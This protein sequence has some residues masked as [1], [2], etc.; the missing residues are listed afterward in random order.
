LA[1]VAG[2]MTVDQDHPQ[3]LVDASGNE[4]YFDPAPDLT[5]QAAATAEG[6]PLAALSPL[7][8]VPLLHS[9]PLA[10]QT[11]FLDFDGHTVTGTGWNSY[12]DGNAIHAAAYSTDSDIFTFSDTEL[13]NIQMIWQR[14][15]EDYA[16]FEVD[17]TTEDPGVSAFTAGST[18]LR[19]LI[20]TDVDS[21]ALGGTGNQWFSNAGGV[22]YLGSWTWSNDTPVWVFENNL[23]NGGEKY[24]AEASSHEAGHAFNLHHDGRTSPSEGYYYGHGSGETGWAPIMGAGYYEN[25]THWSQG[26]YA[27]ANNTEDDVSRIAGYLSYRPD[28]HGDTSGSATFL[29]PVNN[30]VAAD[31]FIGQRSDSDVF[32]FATTGGTIS[33]DVNPVDRGPNLDVLAELYDVGGGLVT[34]SNPVDYLGAGF[35]IFL[36][37]GNYYFTISGTGKGD[38]LGTGYTDYGS[39]GY[40]SFT[41]TVFGSGDD[42]L[43]PTASAAIA[44]ITTESGAAHQFT[45]TYA[46]NVAIDVATIDGNDVFVTGPGGFSQLAELVSIDHATNGAP[47]TATYRI[48]APGDSW[49]GADNGTYQLTLQ[50]AQVADTAGNFAAAGPLGSF[51]VDILV[52]ET[53]YFADMNTDPG[54]S[55]EG[56]WAYGLPTNGNDPSGRNVV[57]YQLTGDG[58]YAARMSGTEWATAPVINATGFT[59]VTLQFDR[60]LGVRNKDHAYVQVSSGGAWTTLYSSA[61]SMIDTSWQTVQYDITSVAAGQST[62]YVRWGMG[63]TDKKLESFGWNIDD[64][65]IT[66]LNG[67]GPDVTAPAASLSATNVTAEGGAT[68]EF[69]VTY[70]DNIAVDVATIDNADVLITGPGGYSQL[71]TLVSVN[72]GTD[73]TPRAAT[74]S[75]AAPGGAWDNADNGTYQVVMQAGQVADTNGN[76]VP[77][78]ALGSF[79]VAI[80]QTKLLYSAD[81]S[82]DPGWTL[83][84]GWVYGTPT[85]SSDP[86][87]RPLVGYN[88][89]GD[90]RYTSRMGAT[91]WAMTPAIDAAG[92]EAVIV[93]FSR[94]L[95]VR[96]KDSAMIQV[97]SDGA[98]WTTIFTSKGNIIDAAWTTVQYDISAVAAGQST[99]YVRWGM[100]PSDRRNESFGWNIDDVELIGVGLTESPSLNQSRPQGNGVGVGVGHE[101]FPP[102]EPPA[103]PPTVPAMVAPLGTDLSD[104][105][106]NVAPTAIDAS[107]ALL[108]ID[109]AADVEIVGL[110]LLETPALLTLSG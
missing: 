33:F 97:S 84:G 30:T 42:T 32:A 78:G 57:G 81:M 13:A 67:G 3:L 31:G 51:D 48:A 37:A 14:V 8:A 94:F 66:G 34:S 69:T 10:D 74:Y 29:T 105:T 36:A 103:V 59:T 11:I 9:N 24:V 52:I 62:V 44:D 63:S 19:V 50:S 17:V 56:G 28:D 6:D 101:L 45:V 41:G 27:N 87:D 43:A 25:L 40:Y 70:S 35:S 89:T 92:A 61:G 58:L 104:L 15:A 102:A 86:T 75:I 110:F 39:L 12:N 22:A 107:P 109:D 79:D 18:A 93:R 4:L 54:W 96:N 49:D 68:H 1:N 95:G 72:I 106:V 71:A 73:G 65:A 46:D 53:L 85:S 98:T 90:G 99:V 2:L 23:G 82:S 20:S 83:E 77:G 26:E 108:P 76:L 91:E 80:V 38:P 100:G 88:N 21:A 16:P 5:A 64:V 60:F 47:R 55:L 7:S